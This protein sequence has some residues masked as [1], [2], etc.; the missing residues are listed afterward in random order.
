MFSSPRYFSDIL[1]ATFCYDYCKTTAC[2]RHTP[3]ILS[4]VWKK[5]KN[6]VL[7]IMPYVSV[8]AT[9]QYEHVFHSDAAGICLLVG[10]LTPQQHASVSQRRICTDNFTCCHTE[11]EVADQIF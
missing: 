4:R 1:D 9:S 10:C 5:S 8:V 2:A 11:I 3:D 7:W 6:E